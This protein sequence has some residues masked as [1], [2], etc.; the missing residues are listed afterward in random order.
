MR[1]LE[2]LAPAKN[3]ECGIAAINH[4]ADAVYIGATKFG[5]RA[6]AGNS[7]D[8]IHK[9]CDYA[10]QFNAKVYVTLNTIVYDNEIE[11][12]YELVKQIKE[13]NVDAVLVQDM[14]LLPYLKD[15]GIPL[16]AST[17]TDNRTIEKVSWLSSLGFK[18]IVLAR[19]LSLDE[20]KNIHKAVPDVELEFFVHGALCVSFS[21]ICYASQYCF[22][23][24]ANRGNCAQFCRLKFNL[25]D[26]DDNE[27][28]H[29]S[30]LLSLKDLCMINHLEELADAGVCS[31]KIEGR[32]KD[33]NYVKNV[34]SAYSMQL[35][36]ITHHRSSEFCRSSLG[37]VKY[38][39]SPDLDKTFNR[40]Y[41]TYFFNGR[42]H[43]ISS[44]DTPK[45]IGEFVGKVKE[46]HGDSFTVS[47]IAS[48]ANGDGLCFF[49]DN[50]ELKGFRVNR[51]VAN[52][53]FPLSMPSDLRPETVLYRNNDEAFKAQLS[54]LT[55]ERKISIDLTFSTTDN[56]FELC[57]DAEGLEKSTANIVFEHQLAM[58]PQKENIIRQLT[59]LGE[60]P[61]KCSNVAFENGSENY[62]IPSSRLTELKR[63]CID[64][65]SVQKEVE[66]KRDEK[67]TE[68]Q[69]AE[70]W[71]KE[72]EEY[73]YLFN[74]SNRLSC[75]FYKKHGVINVDKAFELTEHG[76][77]Q[78]PLIM[79]C[80]HCIRYAL[81]YCV[82]YGGKS[83]TWHEPL[84]LQFSDD[85]KFRL[86]FDC[87]EC[88]MKIY[89]TNK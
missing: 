70:I 48:F 24:S 79:Q 88:V 42:Q 56:G 34:V 62:F 32:L 22:N 10:H 74:S 25:L 7:V 30:H 69:G 31:F 13:A 15:A 41:T 83:P 86:Q 81:G 17:Q 8:D 66:H 21:G 1:K 60:T 23:R 45:A 35:K 71:Q 33:E 16:H 11:E 68:L 84:Y 85:R 9:L 26:K 5:A 82:K 77:L 76:D 6:D 89:G 44:F 27:I 46:I 80:R 52:R 28:I 58:K 87:A 61:Y 47:G 64:N 20:I 37:Q 43:D 49:T 55:S 38:N 12:T 36:K 72:Y 53:L 57:A 2:L 51:V 59:K 29:Q 78:E 14:G 19:E 3:I 73:P 75:D 40:G 67:A 4:G 54:H 18:R 39:F 65:M 63:K 50:H